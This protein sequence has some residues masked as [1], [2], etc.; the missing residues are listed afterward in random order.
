MSL[1]LDVEKTLHSGQRRFTLQIR[2][3]TDARRIAVFGPSGSGKSLLLR[4]IAGIERL[5]RG[6]IEL[7][8]RVLHD[9]AAGVDL[10]PRA[11]GLGYVF[12]DYALF[13]HLDARQN[14]AFGLHRRLLNPSR[15]AR[16]A[17]VEHWLEVLGLREVAG[18]YPAQ[19]SG[20]QRQRTALAR[21]LVTGPRA[22]LLDEPFAA[23]DPA[24]QCELR[25]ELD[26]L[27]RQLDLPVL[28]ISH[29]PEDARRFGEA[30]LEIR[31]GKPAPQ[32][33]RT[34]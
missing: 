4:L 10:A 7:D 25:D 18:L 20:G 2:W 28:L 12:Q 13:P 24:L 8:G 22:L 1:V 27:Q 21:A 30:L 17:A 6:H 33:A 9:S 3:Q 29:D 5:D 11:R 26:R 15:R 23:L 34:S 32:A 16:D 14:V 31:D 19:L